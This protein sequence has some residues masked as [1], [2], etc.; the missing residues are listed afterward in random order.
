[1]TPKLFRIHV[2]VPVTKVCYWTTAIIIHSPISVAA[3]MFIV[4]ELSG[5][6][7]RTATESKS[8]LSGQLQRKCAD[9]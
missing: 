2:S 6:R 5:E 1:M 7:H 8:L 4:A 9:P 3:V